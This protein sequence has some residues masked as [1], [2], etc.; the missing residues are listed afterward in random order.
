MKRNVKGLRRRL[1]ES[2]TG[3]DC[4]PIAARPDRCTASAIRCNGRLKVVYENYGKYGLAVGP[5]SADGDGLDPKA[6]KAAVKRREAI[7]GLARE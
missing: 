2:M 7:V 6:S 3:C 5:G 1:W 4:S